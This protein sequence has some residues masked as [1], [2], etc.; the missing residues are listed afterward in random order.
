MIDGNRYAVIDIGSNSVRLV[1]FGGELRAPSVL[2]NEK[3]MAG[4]GR[5]KN[6]ALDPATMD[7]VLI[8][9]ARFQKLSVMLGVDHPHTVATA[10]VRDASNGQDFLDRIDHIGLRVT[11]LTGEE[12]AK[13]AAYGVI[14]GF[15][16]A[17]GVIG[18]LG[19]GS[20][21]LARV[22]N[23]EVLKR[24]SFPLG[25]LRL[26]EIRAL[27]AKALDR[28]VA[29]TLKAGGWVGAASGLPF[30]LVGGSW[31]AL[32]KIHTHLTR[33]PL[34]ILHHYVMPPEAGLRIARAVSRFNKSAGNYDGIV[35]GAR[36]PAMTDA[37][38]MLVA[39][40]NSLKP[41]SLVVSTTG[42]RE[43]LIYCQLPPEQQQR[44]PLI[45]AARVEA[46]RQGRFS[47]HGDVLHRWLMPLFGDESEGD[48][49]L[50]R[51][52]CLLGDIGWAANPDF[53]AERAL[54]F[55]LHGNWFGV[56]ARGR[57][58]IAQA[59]FSAFGGGAVRP[60]MLEKLAPAADLNRARCW[61][62]GIRVAQ[63]L[64]GGTATPLEKS[65]L[66]VSDGVIH[67]NIAPEVSALGG[68]EAVQRRLRQLA[69]TMGLT[70]NIGVAISILTK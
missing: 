66:T 40:V 30:Y 35:S 70:S 57:A 10:A 11:L 34:P 8:A 41:A 7:R 59:L 45:V 39:C 55:A 25:V 12:E 52:A 65:Q 2:F 58:M 33:H 38:A 43:G 27:G 26:P 28:H 5:T 62:L 32:A 9:L 54:E 37:A 47:E 19:G 64:S 50:R 51:A 23:G 60:P 48:I 61:G 63:R 56:D 17:D 20:L 67:L 4:L 16:K 53:R 6:G 24:A 1:V 15:D 22:K 46:R 69:T 29:A 49:R 44:D 3:V 68:G 36:R 42:V 18:D 14:A 31:R 13:A 21:E